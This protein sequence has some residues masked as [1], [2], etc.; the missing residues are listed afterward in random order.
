MYACLF[1]WLSVASQYRAWLIYYMVP[2]LDNFLGRQY[3]LHASRLASVMHTLLSSSVSVEDLLSIHI[4][5]HLICAR[6]EIA[7]WCSETMSVEALLVVLCCKFM[8][9]Y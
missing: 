3:W 6:Y 7:L 8:F 5:L 2:V 4:L 9:R 1:V